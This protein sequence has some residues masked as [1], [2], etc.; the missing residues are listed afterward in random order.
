MNVRAQGLHPLV[1]QQ[2]EPLSIEVAGQSGVLD[3]DRLDR[4]AS[5]QQR[6]GQPVEMAQMRIAG[7]RIAPL[8]HQRIADQNSHAAERAVPGELGLAEV[9]KGVDDCLDFGGI[10]GGDRDALG[11]VG[12][13]GI[14]PKK[15]ALGP[16][17][18]LVTPHVGLQHRG[19]QRRFP[20][21]PIIF[22]VVVRIVLDGIVQVPDCAAGRPH[23][24]LHCAVFEESGLEGAFPQRAAIEVRSAGCAGPD[25]GD[26]AVATLEPGEAGLGA[27]N[28]PM[29]IVDQAMSGDIAAD[30][31]GMLL[32]VLL[33]RIEDL[34]EGAPIEVVL[35]PRCPPLGIHRPMGRDPLLA[36]ELPPLATETLGVTAANPELGL[37]EVDGLGSGLEGALHPHAEEPAE[38]FPWAHVIHVAAV[39]DLLAFPVGLGFVLVIDAVETPIQIVLVIAPGD[40]GHDVN[41]IAAIAPGVDPAGQAAIHSVDNCD[42][43]P[44]VDSV[45]VSARGLEAGSFQDLAG[46]QRRR[47]IG[48]GQR[49]A[50]GSQPCGDGQEAVVR[51]CPGEAIR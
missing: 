13:I 34:L 35:Q 50:Q 6:E 20:I 39:A 27:D 12:R 29:S 8:E 31:P 51:S 42:I 23:E 30:G 16:R 46:I 48:G 11:G 26:I 15:D 44:E 1:G 17:H 10:R 32:V 14:L 2:Q 9:A 22:P 41:P 21:A 19:R 43:G 5:L 47:G 28:S 37:L 24:V 18:D 45:V 33:D 25:L 38:V 3:L 7:S 49:E 4:N 36:I 40:A